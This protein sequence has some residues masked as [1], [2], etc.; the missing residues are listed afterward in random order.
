M[1]KLDGMLEAADVLKQSGKEFLSAVPK[2]HKM[3]EA[4]AQVMNHIYWVNASLKSLSPVNGMVQHVP[5]SDF[6]CFDVGTPAPPGP[7][8]PPSLPP[9]AAQPGPSGL[10]KKRTA[11]AAFGSAEQQEQQSEIVDPVDPE[12][13]QEEQKDDG[14]GGEEGAGKKKRKFT[15]E[16]RTG[17][18]APC[19]SDCYLEYRCYKVNIKD[20]RYNTKRG[21]PTSFVP[22]SYECHCGKKCED[23]PELALH[24][25][26]DHPTNSI[27]S[28]HFCEHETISKDYLWKH[29]R[30]QHHNKHLHICQF[31]NC[32]K[33]SQGRKYGN[34]ELTSVWAHMMKHHG[35]RNPLGCPLC[36]KTFSGKA[37]Q[38]K[39][40]AT[41]QELPQPRRKKEFKCPKP[42]CAKSYVDQASLDRYLADHDGKI[43]HPQ[44]QYC[45]K[46]LSTQG[47]LKLHI[48]GV[49]PDKPDTKKKE[50]RQTTTLNMFTSF[51]V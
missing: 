39:H 40:I 47:A 16:L 3:F 1:E 49:C 46:Q 26:E 18:Y 37:I 4:T 25:S 13:Q 44:C 34:D 22:D 11:T 19:N 36:E 24:I 9:P 7:P 43:E 12:E 27:W 41:C 14:D 42:D 23:D 30:T 45:G 20:P 28:C 5:I 31:K 15:K 29:V 17:I 38:R 51:R 48:E 35:L 2:D 50:K 8:S 33:G 32:Q 6:D 21:T 10:Q